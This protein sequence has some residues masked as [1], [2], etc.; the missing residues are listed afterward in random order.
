MKPSSASPFSHAQP[1][2]SGATLLLSPTD[3]LVECRGQDIE[4]GLDDLAEHAARLA[5]AP[6]D[7][8]CDA[9][10]TQS[11]QVVD[12]DVAVLAL[13]TPDDSAR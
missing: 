10:I 2:P 4:T 7:E 1:L 11:R 3:R 9:L 5:R 13:R 8:L 6:L 12:D